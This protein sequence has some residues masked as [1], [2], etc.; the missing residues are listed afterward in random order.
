[1]YFAFINNH[2]PINFNKKLK[3]T[4]FCSVVFFI[5]TFFVVQLAVAPLTFTQMWHC[6]MENGTFEPVSMT[7]MHHSDKM[8]MDDHKP[9]AQKT[10]LYC[11]LCSIFGL[12]NP[13]VNFD[14]IL[15]LVSLVV[16]Y[17]RFQIYSAQNLSFFFVNANRQRAPPI[18]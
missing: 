6:P 16:I 14:P 18:L 15:L 2:I 3:K 7:N 5:L 4:K 13:L 12:N 1:M 11:P 8:H 9:L 17:F 10:I